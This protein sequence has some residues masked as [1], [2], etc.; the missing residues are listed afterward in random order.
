MNNIR[1]FPLGQR[2]SLEI[3]GYRPDSDVSAVQENNFNRL[4]QNKRVSIEKPFLKLLTPK[5]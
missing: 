1:A 4:R 2:E 3:V 5:E